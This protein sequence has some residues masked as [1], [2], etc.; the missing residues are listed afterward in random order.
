[1]PSLVDQLGY[2]DFSCTWSLDQSQNLRLN[3]MNEKG[4]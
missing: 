1:M 4:S 2:L 3:K